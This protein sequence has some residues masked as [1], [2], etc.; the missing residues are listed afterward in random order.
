MTRAAIRP[1]ATLTQFSVIEALMVGD[2]DGVFPVRDALRYGDVGIGCTDR[3][4]AEVVVLDGRPWQCRSD[5]SCRPLD[6]NALL[7]FVEMC[8]L[9]P[10]AVPHPLEEM[11]HDG[12]A[13]AVD[14]ALASRNHFH[15]IR[16]DGEFS[17]VRI[18]AT[19]AQTP[20]YRPLAEVAKEQVE[21]ELVG[22]TGTLIGFWS[23]S[24]YQGITVAGLHL[25][26]LA[27]DRS[28]GGHVLDVVTT[29]GTMRVSAYA[30]FDLRLPESGAFLGSSLS[31]DL[32][33]EIVAV[34]GRTAH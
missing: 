31:G 11:A 18:R 15:A 20:P 14:G 34:E 1:G 29:R 10:E 27:A 16:V 32:D 8:H 28:T 23:P 6:P 26:F 25:H 7:P 2:Y 21:H 19:P 30:D 9:D 12:L 13:A 3:I 24:I 5:G 22:M 17:R 33:E 4:E